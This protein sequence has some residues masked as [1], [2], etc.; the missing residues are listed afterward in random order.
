MAYDFNA[1]Y[2]PLPVFNQ[3][4]GDCIAETRAL[5]T[6]AFMRIYES[7]VHGW[8][9]TE[10]QWANDGTDVCKFNIATPVG[11]R[12]ARYGSCSSDYFTDRNLD[13][14]TL[15]GMRDALRR[16]GVM[17]IV[18]P[19][20][21]YSFAGCYTSKAKHVPWL[22][23][24]VSWRAAD[25]GPLILNHSILAVGVRPKGVLVQNS[26]GPKWGK[27]GRAVLSWDFL[28]NGGCQFI[29]YSWGDHPLDGLDL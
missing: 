18:V 14:C 19:A 11:P 20:Y 21:A 9:D 8:D 22:M 5:M 3:K 25:N 13:P 16:N 7:Q 24:V 29:P 26:W 28:R 1:S 2:A 12:V 17:Q 27:R 4:S 10:V 23:P 15:A 6:L